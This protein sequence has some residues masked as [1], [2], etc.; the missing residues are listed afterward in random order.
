MKT[1]EEKRKQIL[2]LYNTEEE[3]IQKSQWTEDWD[4]FEKSEGSRGGK[5]IGHTKSGKPIYENHSHS[6]HKSFTSKDHRDAE[7]LHRG[8]RE[9]KNG[10]SE[11]HIIESGDELPKELSKHLSKETTDNL[12]KRIEST[13]GYGL[14]PLQNKVSKELKSVG[15]DVEVEEGGDEHMAFSDHGPVSEHTE[16]IKHHSKEYFKERRRE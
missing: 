16:A 8:L 3:S 6:S 1:F 4:S 9:K 7:E 2:G 15:R 14:N 10:E 11:F 12:N 5:I 13:R